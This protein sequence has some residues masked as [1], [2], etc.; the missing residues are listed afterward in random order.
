VDKGILVTLE[1]ALENQ[2]GAA[3]LDGTSGEV[4]QEQL[5]DSLR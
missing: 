1:L 2:I 3:A 4:D 5:R